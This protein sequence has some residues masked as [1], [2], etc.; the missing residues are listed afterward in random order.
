MQVIIWDNDINYIHQFQK[1]LCTS[2]MKY[3][4]NIEIIIIQNIEEMDAF[5]ENNKINRE[6]TMFVF[7]ETFI[8]KVFNSK[9]EAVIYYLENHQWSILS[10]GLWEK[11]WEVDIQAFYEMQKQLI[12]PVQIQ[13][14]HKYQSVIDLYKQLKHNFI[15]CIN[16]EI[17]S[18]KGDT[19]FL[20]IYKPYGEYSFS[21]LVQ[22]QIKA[23]NINYSLKNKKILI[24]HYDSFFHK[25]KE[26]T[27]NL[28][29]L[30]MQIR[31][32]KGNMRFILH[33]IVMQLYRNIDVL[34][35]PLNM[36]DYDFLTEGEEEEWL[37]W[38]REKSGYNIIIFNLNGVHISKRFQRLIVQSEYAFLYT[39][40]ES[41]Q[42]SV[43]EQIDA[44]WHV[45]EKKDIA[46]INVCIEKILK[47]Q[48]A[49]V[50]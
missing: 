2:S 1:A 18:N 6:R 48:E 32:K 41:I 8:S 49:T 30:F 24:I 44:V 34:E 43:R 14:I 20:T 47:E 46:N 28:S 27:N 5:G 19:S 35:G 50:N 38:L 36:N 31:R 16:Q 45:T 13:I 21:K 4:M 11:K 3:S 17:I 37:S 12:D 42:K 33:E 26:S 7:H 40:E 23:L 39:E 22:E 15:L 25:L 29:Y 10:E 9:S